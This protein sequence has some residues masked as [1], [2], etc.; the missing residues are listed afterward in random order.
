[1]ILQCCQRHSSPVK[2][3]L[4]YCSTRMGTNATDTYE[5][6][7]AEIE[8]PDDKEGMGDEDGDEGDGNG[9]K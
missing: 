6:H 8:H 4:N 7:C 3:K 5:E 9:K 1:M 2:V